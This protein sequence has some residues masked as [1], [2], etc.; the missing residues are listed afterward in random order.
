MTPVATRV[1][2]IT[3]TSSLKLHP[4]HSFILTK[5]SIESSYTDTWF[6]PGF[7]IYLLIDCCTGA[8]YQHKDFTR[9]VFLG[10]ILTP[11][12]LIS[13][14]KYFSNKEQ[15]PKWAPLAL[16]GTA[17][18]I[19]G[20]SWNHSD[21]LSSSKKTTPYNWQVAHVNDIPIKADIMLWSSSPNKTALSLLVDIKCSCFYSEVVYIWR[22]EVK[23][24]FRVGSI[25]RTEMIKLTNN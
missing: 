10:K 14:A 17:S 12:Q 21:L 13:L 5:N 23:C 7:P 9:R 20:K 15:I 4:N 8:T 1:P 19:T 24:V 16:R 22:E 11:K 3:D 6:I 25:R 18:Q 2:I